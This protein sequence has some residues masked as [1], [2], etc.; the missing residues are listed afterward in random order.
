MMD[1]IIECVQQ[2]IVCHRHQKIK[3]KSHKALSTV[4]TGLFDQIGIDCVFGLPISDI[5]GPSLR[6]C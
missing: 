4:I 5:N 6:N 3:T 1:D 2:C